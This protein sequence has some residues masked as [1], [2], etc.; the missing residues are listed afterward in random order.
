MVPAGLSIAL[1]CKPPE[2]EVHLYGYNW[3]SSMW[4]FHRVPS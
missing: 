1:E 2:A 4:Q 3:H